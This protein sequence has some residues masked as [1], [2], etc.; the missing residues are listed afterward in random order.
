MR[1]NALGP[2]ELTAKYVKE[3]LFG[4][5]ARPEELRVLI[6]GF[7][8]DAARWAC[9][10]DAVKDCWSLVSPPGVHEG[11][12]NSLEIL[13]QTGRGEPDSVRQKT[14]LIAL[15]H[16]RDDARRRSVS[17]GR[18]LDDFDKRFEEWE[19][20]FKDVEETMRLDMTDC[21]VRPMPREY[22]ADEMV[23]CVE[24]L[25]RS[26]KVLQERSSAA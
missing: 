1:A 3:R 20:T 23:E 24:N 9:F 18:A 4:V 13:S 17:R 10:K 25:L 12:E 2:P 11:S 8:R 14:Y 26:W 6:D 15:K 22:G 7:P 19:A 16:D 21:M 5:G